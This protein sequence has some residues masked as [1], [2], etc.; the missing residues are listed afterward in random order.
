MLVGSD[1]HYWPGGPSVAHEAFVLFASGLHL[2]EKPKVIIYN[3]DAFDGAKVSRHSPIG[4]EQRPDVI[5]E[6]EA[7]QIRMQE[8]EE[9]NRS[10]KLVWTIGNH[11]VRF[12]TRLASVA[13][14][15]AHVHGFRLSDHFSERWVHTWAAFINDDVVVKHKF[16]GG[17]HAAHNNTLLG[18]RSLITGHLHAQRIASVTDFNG[19]RYGVDTGCLAYPYGP[20]FTNYTEG[21]PLTWTA[22]FGVFTFENGKMLPPEVVNVWSHKRGEVTFRGEVIKV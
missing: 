19:T 17:V 7:C 2:S 16:K 4:W 3:G 14:E 12:E 9:A 13:P 6:L 21:G 1:G 11:D 15:Y 18:G 22:G 8:I 20:Q 10:A 5:D